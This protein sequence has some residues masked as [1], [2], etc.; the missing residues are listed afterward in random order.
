MEKEFYKQANISIDEDL[1]IHPISGF[2]GFSQNSVGTQIV[3]ARL[4]G[5]ALESGA[6]LFFAF[7]KVDDPY[8]YSIDP[9]LAAIDFNTNTYYTHVPEEVMK[10]GGKWKM[11]VYKKYDFDSV[12]GAAG[13]STSGAPFSFN[14]RNTVKDVSNENVTAYDLVNVIES[15]RSL[16]AVVQGNTLPKVTKED[17]GKILMVRN[18]AWSPELILSAEEES[19]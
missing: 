4:N 2:D 6:A 3:S 7:E 14:V 10:V 12:T 8:N 5:W 18:G 17:D 15:Y 9:I 11:C 16:G 13:R 1:T 19:F